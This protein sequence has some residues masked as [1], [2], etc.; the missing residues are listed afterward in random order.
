LEGR[1]RLDYLFFETKQEGLIQMNTN[2][3]LNADAREARR[4]FR[5]LS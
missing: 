4:I 5:Y 1:M 2:T 3:N